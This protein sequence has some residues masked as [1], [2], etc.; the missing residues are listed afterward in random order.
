MIRIV[1]Y[2]VILLLIFHLFFNSL[3]LLFLKSW[4]NFLSA[5]IGCGLKINHLAVFLC[6]ILDQLTRNTIFNLLL[7]LF[8]NEYLTNLLLRDLDLRGFV[9]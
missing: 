5:K 2:I 6:R 4:Y 1:L 8:L 3:V 9:I 7:Y